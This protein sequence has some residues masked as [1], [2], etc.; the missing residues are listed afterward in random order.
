MLK[1]IHSEGDEDED[2]E[3]FDDDEVAASLASYLGR[4]TPRE[5]ASWTVKNVQGGY[6]VEELWTA[7]DN[8][9]LPPNEFCLFTIWGRLWVG[10]WWHLKGHYRYINGYIHRDGTFALQ[11]GDDE[12]E[13]LPDWLDWSGLVKLAE[14]LGAHKDM[15]RLDVFV[16]VPSSA[17]SLMLDGSTMEERLEHVEMAISES[18]IYPSTPFPDELSEE[19][20]RL[21]IAGY[22]IGNFHVVPNTEVPDEFKR[23]GKLSNDF[24]IGK[25]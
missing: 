15:F 11:F 5:N 1:H 9:D 3:P 6:V 20:A 10:V 21:F 17:K 23:T 14:E 12:E 7:H 22:K 13:E 18:E 4:Q 19:A 8:D 2:E 25:N 16:G 24:E